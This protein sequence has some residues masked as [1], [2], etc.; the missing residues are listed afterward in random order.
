V[1]DK[2]AAQD[3]TAADFLG[4]DADGDVIVVG[5][6]DDYRSEVLKPG[7]LG[8]DD[9]YQ[10][11]VRESDRASAVLFVN[12]NAGDDWLVKLAGDDQSVKENLAPLAGFG[13]TAWQDDDWTHSV[14]RITTDQ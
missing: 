3:D 5:P 7:G 4:T 14:L 10:D 12:F 1:L 6:N 11:V 2:I 8:Q 9:V 13:I